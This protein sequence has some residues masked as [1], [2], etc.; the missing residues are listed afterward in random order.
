[1][2]WILVAIVFLA[3]IAG[4]I[5]LIDIRMD[6]EYERTGSLTDA[7]LVGLPIAL[8][9]TFCLLGALAISAYTG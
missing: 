2:I 6:E 4:S 7:A 3:L 8:I 1:M 9:P 5:L